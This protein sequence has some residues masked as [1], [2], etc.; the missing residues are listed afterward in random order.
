MLFSGRSSCFCHTMCSCVLDRKVYQQ[1]T[2]D[3]S[4]VERHHENSGGIWIECEQWHPEALL[5]R[6]RSGVAHI[7]RGLLGSCFPQEFRAENVTDQRLPT[8]DRPKERLDLPYF[9]L[10]VRAFVVKSTARFLRNRCRISLLVTSSLFF[11][12]RI[13]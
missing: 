12:S 4:S 2:F 11:G 8:S 3:F 10:C 13:L 1:I 5:Q 9:T 6:L 7:Y